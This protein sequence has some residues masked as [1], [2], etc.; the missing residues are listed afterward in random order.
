M[1]PSLHR[2]HVVPSNFKLQKKLWRDIENFR[3]SLLVLNKLHP[4]LFCILFFAFL[5]FLHAFM[6]YYFW[7]F[8]AY[9]FF[10][11][12]NF[13]HFTFLLFC[14]FLH[15][16][17]NLKCK[18]SKGCMNKATKFKIRP[19]LTG[20]FGSWSLISLRVNSFHSFAEYFSSTV[21]TVWNSP[22][23]F[24]FQKRNEKSPFN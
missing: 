22:V 17:W 2:T 19:F 20:F 18:K 14:L 13:L 4:L 8:F 21:V 3:T 11:I 10:L 23:L 15:D 16:F 9:I 7:P 6:K 1:I 12:W 24:F 5:P